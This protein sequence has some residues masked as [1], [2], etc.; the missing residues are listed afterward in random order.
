[1]VTAMF[2]FMGTYLSSSNL[3]S[4]DLYIVTLLL[5]GTIKMIGNNRVNCIYSD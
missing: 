2:G 1:M 5:E 3:H 4:L